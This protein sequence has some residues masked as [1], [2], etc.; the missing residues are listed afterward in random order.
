MSFRIG[1]TLVFLD[2]NATQAERNILA[3]GKQHT[4]G[5]LIVCNPRIA[6]CQRAAGLDPTTD[7]SYFNNNSGEFT[8]NDIFDYNCTVVDTVLNSRNF[9]MGKGSEFVFCKTASTYGNYVVPTND[10]FHDAGGT[11][12]TYNN[13]SIHYS[14]TANI[15]GLGGNAYEIRLDHSPASNPHSIGSNISG[16]NV[17]TGTLI[18][19]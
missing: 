19:V 15:V 10:T 11:Q 14:L 9:C 12:L 7:T 18:I 1:D 8:L 17:G 6:A 16:T 4:S 5:Q 13:T 2:A 3:P